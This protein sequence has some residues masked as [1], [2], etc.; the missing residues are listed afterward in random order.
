MHLKQGATFEKQT[1][2]LGIKKGQKNMN[3]KLL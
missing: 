3:T 1:A 2:M